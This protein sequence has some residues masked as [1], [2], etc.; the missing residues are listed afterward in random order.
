MKILDAKQA[1]DFDK[2][3]SDAQNKQSLNTN[4]MYANKY[5]DEK[6]FVSWL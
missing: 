6:Q 2:N 5:N 1:K 4:T 3:Y